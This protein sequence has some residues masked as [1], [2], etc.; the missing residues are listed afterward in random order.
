MIQRHRVDGPPPV[1]RRLAQF[2]MQVRT[3]THSGAAH[4]P[5]PLSLTDL[6]TRPHKR[7]RQVGIKSAL[8]RTAMLQFHGDAVATGPAAAN[9]D[10]GSRCEH[11]TARSG[12][13]IAATV[14][15][16]A[17]VNRMQSQAEATGER[18]TLHQRELQGWMTAQRARNQS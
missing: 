18:S 16:P 8:P 1:G 17:A 5:D 12:S 3:G 13:E 10:A 9:H 15:L 7:F 4:I 6:I 2:K 11:W 14:H